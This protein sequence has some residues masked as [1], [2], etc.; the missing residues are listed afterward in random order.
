MAQAKAGEA[1]VEDKPAAGFSGRASS[2][3]AK[4]FNNQKD[5]RSYSAPPGPQS[6]HSKD[7][8]HSLLEASPDLA[9]AFSLGEQSLILILN[10]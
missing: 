7:G 10:H 3:P 6:G 8:P 2:I 9:R 4:A 5:T 1:W